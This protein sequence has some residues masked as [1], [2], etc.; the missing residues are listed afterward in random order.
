LTANTPASRK[1]KGRVFQQQVRQDLITALGIDPLDIQSTGMGQSGCDL[2]LSKAARAAFPFGIECKAQENIAI[3][4]ALK[5]AEANAEKERLAPL[6]V[7]KRNRT[8]PYVIIQWDLF[9]HLLTPRG[10]A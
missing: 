3:W 7:I 6:L 4:A 9:L 8:A 10:A 1:S 2:Y 5:Q